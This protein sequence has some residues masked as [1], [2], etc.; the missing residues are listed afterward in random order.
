M[1]I[2][3]VSIVCGNKVAFSKECIRNNQRVS[4]TELDCS[5]FVVFKFAKGFC[6]IENTCT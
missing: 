5:L 2:V 4:K 6:W 3:E 1:S